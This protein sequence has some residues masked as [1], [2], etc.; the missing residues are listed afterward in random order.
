MAYHYALRFKETTHKAKK[1]TFWVAA[2]SVSSVT[3]WY[4]KI[5]ETVNLPIYEEPTY[6]IEAVNNWLQNGNNGRWLMVVDGLD[7][8]YD[9]KQIKQILPSRDCGQILIT[10][11]RRDLVDDL[12]PHKHYSEACIEVEPPKPEESLK[13]FER[14][15][16]GALYDANAKRTKELLVD[17]HLPLVMEMAAKY[18]TR[19]QIASKEM[20]Q[21]IHNNKNNRFA[22]IEQFQEDKRQAFMDFLLRPLL[23][24]SSYHSDQHSRSKRLPT[25]AR[26]LSL[27][28][29]F[30]KEGVNFSL[31]SVKFPSDAI[32]KVRDM[33]AT[34]V[35]SAFLK[36]LSN[37]A[38]AMHEFVQL[39][40]L[41]WIKEKEGRI[42]VLQHHDMALAMLHVCYVKDKGRKHGPLHE[43]EGSS[44]LRKLPYMPHFERF[45]LFTMEDDSKSV[46]EFW[47]HDHAVMAIVTF[48][49]V[50]ID[51]GRHDD[52]IQVLEFAQKH[53][54]GEKRW[55]LGRN[56]IKAYLSR[57]SGRNARLYWDKSEKILQELTNDAGTAKKP[58]LRWDLLLDRVAVCRKSQRYREAW[59]ALK[60]LEKFKLHVQQEKPI[61]PNRH[62]V[63]PDLNPE[64]RKRLAIRVRREEGLIRLARGQ[65]LND[66]NRTWWADRDL[67]AARS[68]F[69]DCKVAVKQWFRKN[70]EWAMEIKGNIADADT[71]IATPE[72]LTEAEE[73]LRKRLKVL[74]RDFPGGR[75]RIW[76]TECKIAAV[77]LKGSKEWIAEAASIL[78]SVLESAESFYGD[79]HNDGQVHSATRNYAYQYRKALVKAG[80]NSEVV[81]LE[82]RF[83]GMQRMKDDVACWMEW[84]YLQVAGSIFVALGALLLLISL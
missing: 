36:R 52:A 9:A 64:Q 28:A 34:L 15:I 84:R 63:G 67:R 48:C 50:Y 56:L 32:P 44:Y 47:L 5:A 11:R 82:K 79:A 62:T 1:H 72:L 41:R 58:T 25:E 12:V 24:Q 68:A 78:Q 59:K 18:M 17:L 75:Q 54:K 30:G 66:R 45:W 40:V 22:Q 65:N 33:L 70:K 21:E 46:G 3:W 31:I 2:D 57:P 16:D 71:K 13:I 49:H 20:Y 61:L 74:K 35:S 81:Q 80:R 69:K 37:D 4:Y 7:L 42:G 53:C 43:K 83:P 8:R 6:Q 23:Q 26:L 60:P 19:K 14:H 29:V 10:T 73:I 55:D 38:Y 39:G 76:D 77:K 51:Q 27:L